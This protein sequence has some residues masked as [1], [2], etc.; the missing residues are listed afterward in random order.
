M[1]LTSKY[2]VPSWCLTVCEMKGFSVHLSPT[3][4]ITSH[5]PCDPYICR[6]LVEL[7]DEGVFDDVHCDLGGDHHEDIR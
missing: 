3:H 1:G 2:T 6:D 4:R 7:G 5:P